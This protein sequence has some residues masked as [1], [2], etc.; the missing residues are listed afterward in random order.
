MNGPI[1]DSTQ[2]AIVPRRC[3]A[4]N[5]SA[6][7]G[8]RDQIAVHLS[9]RS[10]RRSG[11]GGE[12]TPHEAH[13]SELSSADIG[14]WQLSQ[15]TVAAAGC[16]AVHELLDLVQND[17]ASFASR[18]QAEEALLDHWDRSVGRLLDAH[19]P[20]HEGDEYGND[21]IADLVIRALEPLEPL[22]T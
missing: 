9:R 8:Q 14:V 22:V 21:D 13:R 5:S 16:Q 11:W 15:S 18:F 2:A 20:S 10:G 12:K 1:G 7:I 17:R 19:S 4:G 6:L 3:G